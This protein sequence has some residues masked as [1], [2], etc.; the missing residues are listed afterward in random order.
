MTNIP[1]RF[2]QSNSK[3][4]EL[5][6]FDI[7]YDPLTIYLDALIHQQQ[8]V[9]YLVTKQFVYY[10]VVKLLKNSE[11]FIVI[12][13]ITNINYSNEMIKDIM[14]EASIPLSFQQELYHLFHSSPVISFERFLHTLCFIHYSLNNESLTMYDIVDYKHQRLLTH[15]ATEHTSN[16]YHAKEENL[17]HNSYQF[18]KQ[19]LSMIENGD[20]NSLKKLLEEPIPIN[21]GVVANNS[22]RQIKNIFIA[23]TTLVTRSSIKGG[24]D[25]EMAYQLSDIYIQQME[26]L[27]SLEDIFS[28]QYQ[29][30]IDF[31]ERVADSKIPDGISPLIYECIQFVGLNTNQPISVSD[32]A[33]HVN[34]SRAFISRRFKE[35]LGFGLSDYIMSRKIQEA[36]SLLT[37]SEKS[38]SEIS[39]YLCFSSQS[40]F[41]NVFKKKLN[42]TPYEYRRKTLAEMDHT[43]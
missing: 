6:K 17:Q 37:F 22:K 32:V 25:I 40:Y 10:G 4:L 19:Y 28:L 35:E 23:C 14:K 30:L 36:K 16:S 5:P 42:L 33:S 39:S 26:K 8:S 21:P 34:R 9:N 18:E 27:Q 2:Y 31:T 38:I 15:I 20:L 43:M 11:D 3:L 41:Q 1:I 12:G 24:L 29:M 7:T 13:P